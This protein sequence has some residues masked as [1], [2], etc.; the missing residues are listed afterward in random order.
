MA[1]HTP[2]AVSEITQLATA[3]A[4]LKEAVTLLAQR[5]R[6]I[7]IKTLR[8]LTYHFSKQ[9]R[10]LQVNDLIADKHMCVG[11]RCAI[12]LD[13]GRVR[14]R[15]NKCGPKTSKKRHR[16]KADWKEPKLLHIWLVDD[17]GKICRDFAPWIDGTMK[18]ADA[19]FMLLS[20]YLRAL[21]ITAA[22]QVLFIADGAPWIWNRVKTLIVNLNLDPEK[23]FQIVDFYHAV[24]HLSTV[25]N[26]RKSWPN[27]ERKKWIGRLKGYL[28]K[29]K[30]DSVIEEVRKLLRGRNSK[31]I[32]R[33]RNYFAKNIKRMKYNIARENNLPIGSGPMESAIR[34]VINLRMK[35]NGIFWKEEN[36]EAMIML[37]S[38][39]KA[40]RWEQLVLWATA[41]QMDVKK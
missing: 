26:L 21:N 27:K 6:R 35:G 9:A 32:N 7:D 34:R 25:A 23:V 20:Y 41:P 30:I 40:G 13:G 28:W 11:K 10:N 18:G 8:T 36:A 29:G 2:A 37:R 31:T 39:Y 17:T 16:Y 38:F 5:G 19:V 14:T 1:H 33:E 4:S 3:L 12:S 24:E 15:K 22:Y